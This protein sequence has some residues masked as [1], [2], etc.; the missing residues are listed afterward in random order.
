[1]AFIAARTRPAR[2]APKNLVWIYFGSGGDGVTYIDDIEVANDAANWSPPP[3]APP[4]PMPAD[5]I[6]MD[7]IRPQGQYYEAT[8]P[9]TLDLAERARLA[10]HGL[11]FILDPAMSYAPWGHFAF[12][13]AT[14]ALLDR[15]GGP[16]NWGKIVEAMIRTRMM[17]G[18]TLRGWTMNYARSGG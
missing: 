12:D 7:M 10:V 18:R 6:T 11:T 13:S 5:V 4:P 16:P 3:A 1:M 15:P 9:D 2:S 17:C 8:I 14:P